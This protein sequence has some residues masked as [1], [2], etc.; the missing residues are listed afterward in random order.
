MKQSTLDFAFV[1]GLIISQ[2][3]AIVIYAV[4]FKHIPVAATEAAIGS[5][6]YPYFQDIH[7]MIFVGFGFLLTS[8]H[9]FRL[10]SLVHCFWVAAIAVQYYFLWNALWEPIIVHHAQ[11]EHFPKEIYITVP[12]LILGE[13]S[14]GAMLIAVCAI[15]GKTNSLQF[16]IISIAGSCLYTL[17]EAI[18]VGNLKCRDVGGAMIIHAFGAFYGIG[19]TMM[20]RYPMAR[21]SKNLLES[22]ESLTS[23]MVGT[24]FLWCFWPSFNGALAVTPAEIHMAVLNTYFS[25]IGSCATCY[26]TSLLLGKGRFKMGQILN[27]TLAGGVIMGSAADILYDG[28][29]AYLCGCL[30][31]IISCLCFEYMPRIL[32]KAGI[33]DVAGVFNLHGIPGMLGGLVAAICRA[34]YIDNKGGNQVAGTFIS[35]GMGLLGGIIVGAVTRPLH[36][37]LAHNDYFND[38]SQ[39]CLEEFVESELAVYGG[40][41]HGAIPPPPLDVG[42]SVGPETERANL[43]GYAK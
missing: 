8:F 1:V 18:V 21:G 7:I 9:R 4:Y 40:G 10:S 33:H 38:K 43:N 2:A 17:N 42:R 16:L 20:Y 19:L 39:V 36:H 15:I 6:L 41:H 32:D 31:G 26:A 29:V 5:V 37:Y 35:I 34:K 27:A 24:L 11:S 14:A 12:K 30:I 25:I 22:H 3:V 28:W 23:A 13:V